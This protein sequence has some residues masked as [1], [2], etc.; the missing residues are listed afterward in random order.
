MDPR[1]SMLQSLRGLTSFTML[2][3]S[4]YMRFTKYTGVHCDRYDK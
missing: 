3:I 4:T 2:H 1:S